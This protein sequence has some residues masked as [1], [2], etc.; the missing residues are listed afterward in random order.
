[1]VSPLPGVATR[2]RTARVLRLWPSLNIFRQTADVFARATV[3]MEEMKKETLQVLEK[4]YSVNPV[5]FG[6]GTNQT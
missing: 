2:T 3:K 4:K 1:V 6:G 5:S